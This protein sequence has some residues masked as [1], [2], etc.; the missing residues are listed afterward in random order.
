MDSGGP[1]NQR[2]KCPTCFHQCY[3]W[4]ANNLND[5]DIGS[6]ELSTISI[7]GMWFGYKKSHFRNKNV[8]SSVTCPSVDSTKGMIAKCTSV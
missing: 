5:V 7:Q 8:T 4:L 3:K 6:C 2:N 1:T